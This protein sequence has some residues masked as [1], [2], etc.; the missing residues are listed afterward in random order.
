M[1]LQHLD[2][3]LPNHAGSAQYPNRKFIA[4]KNVFRF[5]NSLY[6]EKV[7]DQAPRLHKNCKL[8]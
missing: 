2:K 6:L 4:H 3:P 8:P 5:Y 1:T 7:P